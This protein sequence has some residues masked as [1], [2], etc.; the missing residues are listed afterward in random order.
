MRWHEHDGGRYMCA[1]SC[2]T[3]DPES[4]YIN[5]GSYRFMLIDKNTLVVHIGSG[6]HGDV[7]RKKYWAQGKPCP[8]AI[9][10]GQDPSI[11]VA[12]GTN[13]AFNEPEYDYTGWLR[14]AP[15]EVTPG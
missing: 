3:R 7:I 6:H 10:L 11:F 15:V 13:L 5:V 1:T 4:G 2:V 9:S 12:A 14:G 8:I